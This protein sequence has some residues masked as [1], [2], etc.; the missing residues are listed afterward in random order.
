M[1]GGSDVRPALAGVNAKRV[2]VPAIR[3]MYLRDVSAQTVLRAA[4]L[5]GET[6][7]PNLLPHPVIVPRHRANQSQHGIL[8][9]QPSSRAASRLVLGWSLNS[10]WT[11]I[12][13]H[14]GLC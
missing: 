8:Q 6:T 13:Q 12:A 11:Q 5:R 1:E 14:C 2:N 4:T 3:R 10:L 7:V 9:S